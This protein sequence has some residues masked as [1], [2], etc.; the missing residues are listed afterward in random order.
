MIV[1][2]R[3]KCYYARYTNV[4]SVVVVVLRREIVEKQLN[5]MIILIIL[6]LWYSEYI[7]MSSSFFNYEYYLILK[8]RDHWVLYFVVFSRLY[9]ILLS[10]QNAKI[11]KR[12]ASIR[13]INVILVSIYNTLRIKR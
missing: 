13:D 5:K 6:L 4:L 1:I 7:S 11:N 9:D 8:F 3:N 10:C 2:H 12:V